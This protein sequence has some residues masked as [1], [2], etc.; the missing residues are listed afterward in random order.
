[1]N[2]I[3]LK[4]LLLKNFNCFSLS[5]VNT[6]AGYLVNINDISGPFAGIVFSISNAFSTIPG[7]I[8]PLIASVLTPHGTQ[9]E[10][11]VVFWITAAVY[12]VGGLLCII[13]LEGE[14]QPWAVCKLQEKLSLEKI[15]EVLYKEEKKGKNQ[16]K[17]INCESIDTL[18]SEVK[19][20]DF[21]CQ[22]PSSSDEKLCEKK[23]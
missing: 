2:F 12:I 4:K 19:E 13:L 22:V 10:W 20:S 18:T 8:S 14:T 15:E 16:R 9:E 3:L 11:K 17:V 6:V 1:M 5:S 21:T 23:V 7:M